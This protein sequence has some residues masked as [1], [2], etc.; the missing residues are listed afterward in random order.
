MANADDEG[1]TEDS[2]VDL[3]FY[4]IKYW[5]FR[6]QLLELMLFCLKRPCRTKL[7]HDCPQYLWDM[8]SPGILMNQ[9]I[10]DKTDIFSQKYRASFS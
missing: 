9:E 5:E 3:A 1:K 8:A 10:Q 4:I 7:A 2:D 6:A